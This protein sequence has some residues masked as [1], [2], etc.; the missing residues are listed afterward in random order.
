MKATLINTS[1][2]TERRAK[3]GRSLVYVE[4]PFDE[5]AD[6]F[7]TQYK[8]WNLPFKCKTWSKI[9]REATKIN[10]QAF[11]ELFPDATS[12]KFSV[13]AGC[14][15]GCS[16]GYIVKTNSAVNGTN[17]WVTIEAPRVHQDMFRASIFSNRRVWELQEE[18]MN[19]NQKVQKLA[20]V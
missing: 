19:Y 10:I 7:A 11:K 2:I 20:E 9:C 3:A 6:Q 14:R 17:N 13:K 15:C 4:S 12:I 8:I 1:P 5:I 18:M 16:P